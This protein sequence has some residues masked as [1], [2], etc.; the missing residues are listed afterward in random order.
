MKILQENKKNINEIATALKN[1]AVLVCPTDTVYG[2]LAD[3][4][5]KKSV[6]KIYKIK[7]RPK[8]KDLPI[9]VGDFKM[10]KNLAEINEKQSKIIKAKWPGKYT[11]VLKGKS[12][13]S[14][15]KIYG[16]NKNTIALR[17]PKYKFLNSI[18]K[19]VD[20]PLVQTS[21]NVSGQPSLNKIGDIINQLNKQDVLIIDGG[22]LK[23]S[24]PSKIIDLTSSSIKIIR[25]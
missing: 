17:I 14:K 18:L 23:K 16:I 2:F 21:V 19:K 12:L 7:K 24:K 11:F 13:K 6:D 8:V 15:V 20:R 25:K 3:S 9:F 1:G 5:N 22:N 10:A 4:T